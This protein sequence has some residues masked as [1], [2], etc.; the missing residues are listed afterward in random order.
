MARKLPPLPTSVYSTLGP[1]PVVFV[2]TFRGDT[3]DSITDGK[4]C[5]DER[6]I[7]LRAN[8][9]LITQWVTL[10]HEW[11]HVAAWDAGIGL[12]EEREERVCDALSSF[13]FAAGIRLI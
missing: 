2:D 7:K 12:D 9:A 10:Y 6:C 8:V 13:L 5:P 3:S 1:V 11:L 4:W